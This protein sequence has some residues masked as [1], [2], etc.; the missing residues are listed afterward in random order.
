M[1]P[2]YFPYTYISD[3]AA[4]A[5]AACFGQFI[6]YRPLSDK[7]PLSMQYLSLIHISEPTRLQV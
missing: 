2:I 6:V 5:V 7:L 4:E 1:K 3:P